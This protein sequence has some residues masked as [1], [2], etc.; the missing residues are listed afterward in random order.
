[1]VTVVYGRR[2]TFVFGAEVPATKGFIH[3]RD[4]GSTVKWL[5]GFV[6]AT[7]GGYVGWYLGEKAG[8]MMAFI[9]SMVGTG[10]GMYYGRKWAANYE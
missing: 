3:M 10:L 6:G 7:L 5:G 4:T 1:M 8:F 9:L 2:H